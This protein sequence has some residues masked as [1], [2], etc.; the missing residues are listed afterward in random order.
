MNLVFNIPNLFMRLLVGIILK[1]I[2]KKKFKDTFK[3]VFINHVLESADRAD[4]QAISHPLVKCFD[5][6]EKHPV[7]ERTIKII[8]FLSLVI[9]SLGELFTS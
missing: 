6:L 8:T 5:W 9:F 1:L 4:K 3:S 7:S 2:G